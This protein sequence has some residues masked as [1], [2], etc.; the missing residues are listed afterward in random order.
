MPKAT[1][2]E[3]PWAIICTGELHSTFSNRKGEARFLFVTAG[4]LLAWPI[5]TTRCRLS[6]RWGESN[7]IWGGRP[8]YARIPPCVAQM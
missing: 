4:A 7:A 2:K 8:H 3:I 6:H 1:T 5:H